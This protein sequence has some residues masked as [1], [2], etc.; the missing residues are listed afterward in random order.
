M[1]LDLEGCMYCAR[2]IRGLAEALLVVTNSPDSVAVHLEDCTEVLARMS[3]EL[4]ES[5]ER[6]MKVDKED[7]SNERIGELASDE[8]E[9]EVKKYGKITA[10][11]TKKK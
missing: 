5:L 11:C 1:I 4:C 9:S 7:S 3:D 6:I 8:V 10:G 2:E